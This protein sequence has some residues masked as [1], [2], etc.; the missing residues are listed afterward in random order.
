MS[1]D[2]CYG[3]KAK[4]DGECQVATGSFKS[5]SKDLKAGKEQ[6]MQCPGKS[7]PGRRNSKCNSLRPSMAM[8]LEMA[9]RP[10]W[11]QQSENGEWAKVGEA[12]T[13]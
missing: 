10:G 13:N 4:A 3:G 1:K 8:V 7:T 2:K 12:S 6:A 5:V 9:E 11:L